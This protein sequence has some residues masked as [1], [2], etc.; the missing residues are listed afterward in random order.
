LQQ[1]QTAEEEEFIHVLSGCDTSNDSCENVKNKNILRS[2]E[3][4]PGTQMARKSN[5]IAGK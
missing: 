5:T 3:K 2:L 1:I 4:K